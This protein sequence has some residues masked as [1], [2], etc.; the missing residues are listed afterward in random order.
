L[1][2]YKAFQ[3]APVKSAMGGR[4]ALH[5]AG[6]VSIR[7]PVKN[8]I[9]RRRVEIEPVEVSIR[10]PVKSAIRAPVAI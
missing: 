4:R 9:F 3:S 5:V 2:D 1:L 8:A 7:A 6:H 10:A